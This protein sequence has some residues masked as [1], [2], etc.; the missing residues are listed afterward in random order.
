MEVSERT[1]GR[2][3][4]LASVRMTTRDRWASTVRVRSLVE[5]V[6]PKGQA[7]QASVKP[8]LAYKNSLGH[9]LAGACRLGN[10]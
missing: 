4:I 2:T 3:G 6:F 9:G 10:A 5:P 8:G 7:G 1:P